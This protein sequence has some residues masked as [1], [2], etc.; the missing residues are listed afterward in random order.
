M[1]L[2]AWRRAIDDTGID[3]DRELGERRI[4]ATLPWDVIDAGVRKNYLKAEWRRAQREI[5]TEDCKWGHCYRCGIP[6][7]GEDTQLA[8]GSL[9]LVG[10]PLPA[11]Q[12]PKAA[13]YRLRP[14]PMVPAPTTQVSQPPV[15]RRYRFT[16]SKTGAARFMS[17]RQVMD[18]LERALRGARVPARYTEGF[19]PH[20][21]VSMGP[22]LSLGHEG[23]SEVFDVDC[24]APVRPAHVAAIN[25]L[26]PDGMEVL[27]AQD[28][29][30][31]APSLGKMV[32]AARYRIAPSE[33]EPWPGTPDHLPDE[34]RAGVTA[35]E[36]QPDGQLRVELNQRQ[37][38]QPVVSVKAL[39]AALG[40]DEDRIRLIRT[41]RERLVLRPKPK[42]DKIAENTTPN[43]A[44][45]S[46]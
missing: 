36:R 13:A 40:L 33:G 16:F 2:D 32:A 19:N 11:D 22:A 42:P 7:D 21:R 44:G 15:Y 27:E 31:G 39:L 43:P 8:D 5:E 35:W 45:G 29:V 4:A 10:T 30:P 23:L 9:P 38:D 17:H 12:Q 3:L 26:L 46:K 18:A 37:N 41:T 24:T 25:H 6:G 34:I 1:D 28:L 14:E 20:I